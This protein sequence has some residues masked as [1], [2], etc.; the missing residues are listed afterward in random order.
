MNLFTNELRRETEGAVL[1][2]QDDRTAGARAEGPAFAL[3]REHQSKALDLLGL[4]DPSVPTVAAESIAGGAAGARGEEDARFSRDLMDTYLHQMR[5]ADPL[6]REDE[7]ALAKRIES[8]RHAVLAGL[9]GVPILVERIAQW[10]QEVAE[11]R[12][13]AADL[14]D[15]AASGL[16]VP[17]EALDEAPAEGGAA[18]E[19]EAATPATGETGPAAE[20]VAR[21]EQLVAVA[22]ELASLSRQRVAAL[23]RGRELRKG[24]RTRLDE[25][26]G[27]FV[28]EVVALHLR[29]DR[30]SDLIEELT[31][32]QH[33]LRQTEHE[34]LRLAERSG[35]ARKDLL[36]R[37][38]G[39]ELDPDWLKEVARLRRPGWRI[40]VRQHGGRVAELRDELAG[41]VR[42]VGLP[43]AD[44]RRAAAGV[45]KARRELKCA[46]EEMVRA[47]LRLVV[48]IAKKY[49]RRC[50]LDLLDLIQ[51]GNMGLMHAVEKF[52]HRRGVKVST[53]AVWW[54]RQSI[55]RAIADQG[56]T[57]RIPVHMAETATKVLREGRKL[58]QKDGRKAES[59]EIAART[60]IPVARVEQVLSLAQEPASLDVPIGEDGDATLG[61][62]IEAPDAVDPHR[63]AEASALKRVVVE[64][65]AE[66]TPR[67]Q[68]ILCMR[69]GIGGSTD[70]TLEEV[71]KEFG[72][73]RERI[74][75]IEAKALEKLRHPERSHKLAGFVER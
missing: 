49:R 18:E 4:D 29:A 43:V 68:R 70:H 13:R 64:A 7:L 69:F 74:R 39:R 16:P 11:G 21:F 28:D 3:D 27:V 9:C 61:D 75:Q 48:A 24:L 42:R 35:L 52:D 33:L 31:R 6:S 34:L 56:R 72:V 12:R 25:L 51:E 55:V 63:A 67:E 71:G 46:R 41:L 62:L 2:R 54:I 50:S 36:E 60:G 57:I 45:A 32:E 8:A 37:H 65:L 58:Y 26:T 5:M 59:G 38:E 66:L 14:V 73:T 40:F 22:H 20:V 23:A 30:L 47:H 17:G 10:A 15:L 53:Y 44:L 1:E 19:A